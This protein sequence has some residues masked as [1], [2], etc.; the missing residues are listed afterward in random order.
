MAN[1][2]TRAASI[3]I[4]LPSRRGVMKAIAANPAF[5]SQP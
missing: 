4:L 1:A 2:P 5:E 3:A